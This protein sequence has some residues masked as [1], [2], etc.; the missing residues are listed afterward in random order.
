MFLKTLVAHVGVKGILQKLWYNKAVI[1]VSETLKKLSISVTIVVAD[2]L[3]IQMKYGLLSG[4][5][6]V[7]WLNHIS[8]GF[9][10][11]MFECVLMVW[12]I[13]YVN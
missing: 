13:P 5:L 11:C 7:V 12:F 3:F 1:V 8:L 2:N 4:F 9:A 6:E 10:I